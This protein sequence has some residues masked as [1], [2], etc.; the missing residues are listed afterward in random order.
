MLEG[1]RPFIRHRRLMVRRA[2]LVAVAVAAFLICSPWSPVLRAQ[3]GAPPPAG[4]GNANTPPPKTTA[5]ILGQVVD[6]TTRQPIGEAVVTLTGAGMRGGPQLGQINS[7]SL[8]PQQQQALQATLSAAAAAAGRGPGGPLRV[9]TG[10]DGRFVFHDLA[11]GTYQLTATQTGYTSTLSVNA[12]ANAGLVGIVAAAI[13]PPSQPTIVP[14]K[15][16]ELATNVSLRLW[17]NAV[18]SGTVLDDAGE[19]AIGLTVQVARRVMGGGRAR[20][21]PGTSVRT[22]DRGAYRLTGLV[23]SDYLVVV[24]QTQVSMPSAILSGL[25]EGLTSGGG[26]GP[27]MMTMLDVMSSGINPTDAMQGGVRIGDYM[28]A[29]SGSVPLMGA[30]GRLQAYQTAFYPSASAPAQATVISLKSGEEKTNVNFQL[31][32]IPTSRVSGTATGPDGPVANLGVRLVVPGD[33]IIAESEFDVATAVTRA[34]GTFS[35]YGVP[36]GQFLLRANKQPRPD[37]P[38]EV[39]AQPG[40]GN[41]FAGAN[42]QKGPN[43]MLFATTAINVASGDL[44]GV[45]VRLAAGFHVSGRVEFE[46][47]TNRPQPTAAQIQTVSVT[48]VPM[49]GRQPGGLLGDISGPDRANDKSEFRTK[50]YGPGK[51]FLNVVGGGAWQVKSAVLGGR[52]VLDGPLEIKEGDVTGIVV[53]FTDKMGTLTGKVRAGAETD[54]SEATVLLFPA[55]YRGWIDN[56]MN[57]RRTRTA[58]AS[59]PGDYGFGNVPVG[60]YLVVALDRSNEGDMQDPAFIE[61]LSRVAT[62]VTIALD[63]VTLELQRAVVKR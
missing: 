25:V 15:E 42:N 28:V 56:G 9:M 59:R 43:D 62:R 52:D 50:G 40:I 57:P 7:A 21:I 10:A 39:L 22:D 35:F 49:D 45:V 13:A 6:G 3:R 34:D 38:A 44:D 5:L 16:G 26:M 27:S 47:Q 11:P 46:S 17:K 48:L 63:P 8:S 53:T 54:L 30:D 18:I 2:G 32:L 23:P 24:P 14:L 36:P 55:N 33:G 37:I 29:S 4:Q 58:R 60:D 31:S 41:L 12:G 61:A 19:P 20:F 51:Y 1:W